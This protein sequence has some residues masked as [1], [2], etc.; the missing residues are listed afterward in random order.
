[1]LKSTNER[2]MKKTHRM[3]HKIPP[4]IYDTACYEVTTMKLYGAYEEVAI[5]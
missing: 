2:N 4:T 3:M 1:M 5:K